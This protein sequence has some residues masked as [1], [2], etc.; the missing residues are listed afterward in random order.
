MHFTFLSSQSN[1][2]FVPLIKKPIQ[3]VQRSSSKSKFKQCVCG[4]VLVCV[5][6]WVGVNVCE[7]ERETVCVCECECMCVLCDR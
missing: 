5:C 1:C 6:G 7:S 2:F 3:E 4:W